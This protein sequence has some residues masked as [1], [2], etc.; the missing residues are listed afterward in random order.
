MRRAVPG[1][2]L[3]RRVRL[4]G[5][6]SLEETSLA[7]ERPTIG[8]APPPPKTDVTIAGKNEVYRCENL[9]GPFLVRKIS[10]PRPPP[11]PPSSLLTRLFAWR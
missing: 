8:G 9:V 1:G 10:G 4:L 2:P 5:Q 3:C 11:H 7:L 6:A